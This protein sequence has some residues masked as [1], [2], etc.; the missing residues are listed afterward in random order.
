MC[1]L[2]M[3]GLMVCLMARRLT[4]REWVWVFELGVD[5]QQFGCCPFQE[6]FVGFGWDE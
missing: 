6:P 1:V 5:L 4:M 2:M 3:N